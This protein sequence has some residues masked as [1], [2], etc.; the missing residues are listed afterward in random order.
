MR[1]SHFYP[2]KDTCNS[3]LLSFASSTALT[4]WKRHRHKRRFVLIGKERIVSSK[5]ESFLFLPYRGAFY[6]ESV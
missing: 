4:G 1:L 2:P 3:C 6:M 5:C